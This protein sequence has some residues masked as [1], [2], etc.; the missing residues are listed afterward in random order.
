MCANPGD[1]GDSVKI[2]GEQREEG[3]IKVKAKGCRVTGGDCT[4]Q[5]KRRTALRR[6]VAGWGTSYK[7]CLRLGRQAGQSPMDSSTT[8]ARATHA[9][10]TLNA[11]NKAFLNSQA[12]VRHKAVLQNVCYPALSLLETKIKTEHRQAKLPVW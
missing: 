9:S 8:R 4:G 2:T 3:L 1:R 7:P 12:E 6:G 10:H 5:V 11:F